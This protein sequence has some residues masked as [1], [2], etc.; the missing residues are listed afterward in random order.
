MLRKPY[1]TVN[2]Q[3]SGMVVRGRFVLLCFPVTLFHIVSS[4]KPM[5]QQSNPR[6]NTSFLPI[7]YLW[8]EPGWCFLKTPLNMIQVM[9]SHIIN[10]SVQM[11]FLTSDHVVIIRIKY[12]KIIKG[13]KDKKINPFQYGKRSQE[14]VR[15]SRVIC[16]ENVKGQKTPRK[17]AARGKHGNWKML[18]FNC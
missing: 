6:L 15:Y 9:I 17:A 2:W 12:S 10:H 1:N 14:R 8:L 3:K 18:A 16:Q 4:L 11:Q 7:R 13:Q 5:E